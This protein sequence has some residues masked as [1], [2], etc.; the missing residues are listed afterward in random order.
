MYLLTYLHDQSL[1]D[2]WRQHDN[3]LE[4]LKPA[5]RCKLLVCLSGVSEN[6]LFTVQLSVN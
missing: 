1:L 5:G 2:G 4:I 6:A 3:C